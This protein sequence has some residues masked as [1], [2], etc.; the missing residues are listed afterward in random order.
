VPTAHELR[1]FAARYTAAWNSQNPASVAACYSQNG[2]LRIND[3]PPA[4]GRDAIT[5]VAQGFMCA[6]PD[7]QVLMDGLEEHGERTWFHW[8]LIGSNTGPGGSGKQVHVSGYEDWKI[9]PD[10]L[11]AESFGHFDEA[12]YQ[13]QRREG[14][15]KT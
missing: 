2:S 11:I 13:R 14:T 7:M 8:T 12:E 9:G 15:S 5:A 1:T 6:F 3:S 4:V 10:G